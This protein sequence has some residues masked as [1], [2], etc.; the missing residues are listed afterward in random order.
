A[1]ATGVT[2]VTG[3]TGQTGHTGVTG[4]TGASGAPGITTFDGIHGGT[5]TTG[6]NLTVG[7]GTVLSPTGTGVVQANSFTNDPSACSANRF[8]TDISS[9]LGTTCSQPTIAG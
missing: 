3:V 8:I 7:N 2:G 6:D 5:N 9:S 4:A 1:G